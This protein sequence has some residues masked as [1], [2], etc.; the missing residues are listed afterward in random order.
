MTP[1]QMSAAGFVAHWKRVGP[2][3]AKI[4]DDE[5]DRFDGEKD[6]PLVD[7]LLQVGATQPSDPRTTSGLVELQCLFRRACG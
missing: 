6:W 7:A 4:R 5:L 2:I 1:E 3:L